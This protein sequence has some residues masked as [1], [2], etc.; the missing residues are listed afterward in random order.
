M[1]GASWQLG[2]AMLPYGTGLACTALLGEGVEFLAP[3][4]S[5][6]P[7]VQSDAS[8]LRPPQRRP[9]EAGKI[10]PPRT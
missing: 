6:K 4:V 10:Q 1:G 9:V 8:C 3:G 5:P 7:L 2:R